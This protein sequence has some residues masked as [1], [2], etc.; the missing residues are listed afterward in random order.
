MDEGLNDLADIY[1]LAKDDNIK[2]LCASIRKP[3][4]MIAQTGWIAP[5]LNLYALVAPQVPHTGRVI[6]A[7]CEQML[8]MAAYGA[9]IYK[10]TGRTINPAG[11]SRARLKEFKLHKAMV[12]NHNYLEAP[13]EISESDTVMKYLDQLRT[14]L[15]EILG[16]KMVSLAYVIL[17]DVILV[18]PLPS[19]ISQVQ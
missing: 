9:A 10:S 3:A 4:G 6:L 18:S 2:T 14:C 16:M 13:P 11:L 8:M 15:H 19:L 5:T 1:E 17:D 7:I 12:D